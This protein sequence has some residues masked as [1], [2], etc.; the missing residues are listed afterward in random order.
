MKL[1]TNITSLNTVNQLSKITESL[2]VQFKRLSSGLRVNSASDDAA[3]LSISVRMNAQVHG[4]QAA[5]RNA[6]DFIS[7]F[8]TAEGGLGEIESNLQR[9]RELA[10]N[11]HHRLIMKMIGAQFRPRSFN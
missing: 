7:L 10:I 1:A 11:R 8:Q 2:S 6:N 9:M 5:R 3:G 4:I